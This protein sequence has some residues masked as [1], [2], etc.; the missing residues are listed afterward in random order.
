VLHG[1]RPGAPAPDDPEHDSKIELYFFNF[2]NPLAARSHGRQAAADVVQ[3]ARL[4]TESNTKVPAAVS[5]TGADIAF[6]AKKVLFFGHS[7]GSLNGPM[8][9]AG[10]DLARGGV[11]SGAG[12]IIGIALLEKTKPVDIPGVLR[13]LAHL[14][15]DDGEKEFDIYHPV[16][17]LAQTMID[18]SDAIHYGR[19]IIKEPRAGFAPKSIYQTEGVTA[20][21]T[22]DTYTPPKGIEALSIALGL[23]RV[24]PG[25]LAIPE[26][27]WAGLGDVTI[28]ADG[29]SGNLGGGNAT[30][31]LA[32]FLPAKNSD[33][34]FVV[35]DVPA[36]RSQAAEFCKALAA[37]PV[38][39]VM[40]SQ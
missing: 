22:G 28:P 25:V 8:F 21:D 14:G 33:G 30:G 10:S 32:Q 38:G 9:F 11:L 5:K 7:Q 35:F 37:D 3:Q 18:V 40:P 12:S 29:L 31:V 17:T 34:H 39:R 1:T 2:E 19:M 6:D 4:F 26:A 15:G 24:A 20:D 16:I 27:Q 13:V 36:A 23:P